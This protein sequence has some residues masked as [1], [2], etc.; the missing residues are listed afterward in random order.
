MKKIN[1]V[2]V[3]LTIFLLFFFLNYMLPVSVF[4]FEPSNDEIYNGIDVSVYQGNIDYEKVKQAGIE[5]V[6]IKSSEGSNFVDPK[7]ERNYTE[8]R[9]NGLKIGFYHYVTARTEEE[10]RRQAEFF[11][12]TISGKVADCK[13]AMDFESFGN[14]TKKEINSIGL[15]FLRTLEEL[16]KKEAVLYSNAYTASYI[17]E[18]E[19]TKYPLW[20]AQYGVESPQNNG[21]WNS[22]QGWQY[23]DMGEIAG[24]NAY[25]DRD[26]YTKDIFL[27]DGS[28]IP[29]PEPTPEPEPEP[30]PNPNPEPEKPTKTII[31]K[32][33]DTLSELALKYNTTVQ[34]LV[35]LNNIA[36]PNLIYAGAKLIVPNNEPENSYTQIYV[37]KRGDT[38]S[39]IAQKFDTTVQI[40]AKDN[41]IK[42]VNLI[43]VGQRL[44]IQRS[45]IGDCGHILYTVRR[46]DTLWSIARRYNT[47]VANIV[48]LNRIKNPNLIYQGQ[49]FRIR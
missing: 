34:E 20:I 49:M 27:S 30:E 33:G 28:E 18:G 21:T 1:W 5:V 3:N 36:N 7:F 17:W 19:V 46:G 11:V 6:Y 31:I 14:L 42:N 25:V 23:S 16:S 8:A 12:S 47:T 10:A 4:A 41:N 40:I 35:K 38:L 22:W 43:Y 48:M 13:L 45:Y 39:Q 44:K 2:K 24:I 32:W 9:K 29:T 15:T 26:K 37:V